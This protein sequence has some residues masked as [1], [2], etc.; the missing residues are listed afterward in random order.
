MVDLPLYVNCQPL[1][2]VVI[3]G[4]EFIAIDFVTTG[5]FFV[6]NVGFLKGEDFDVDYLEK[7]LK[8]VTL[9]P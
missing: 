7:I 6:C 5:F 9:G 3:A 2:W 8:A 4:Y 1:F